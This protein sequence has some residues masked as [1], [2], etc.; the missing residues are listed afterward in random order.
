MAT[1]AERKRAQRLRDRELA[2]RVGEEAE[3]A[4]WPARV[5][6]AEIE[7]HKGNAIGKDAW[8]RLGRLYGWLPSDRKD[9][10]S[11]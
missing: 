7:K 2:G 10:D 3:E 4:E 8:K 5:C 11:L 1:A 9:D 6:L